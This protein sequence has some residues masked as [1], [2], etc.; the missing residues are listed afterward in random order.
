[1]RKTLTVLA[2]IL[3]TLGLAAVY[4]WV[5]EEG[6]VVFSDR[7]RDGAEEVKLPEVSTYT[8]APLPVPEEP[9]PAQGEAPGYP[10]LTI[11]EPAADATIWDAQGNV[12]VQLTLKPELDTTAGHKIRITIDGVKQAQESTNP[13]FVLTNVARGTHTL[14]VSVIDA[15]GKVLTSSDPVTFH[16]HRPIANPKPPLSPPSS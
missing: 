14:Q 16:L 5:D 6:N 9:A 12:P 4:K 15:D 13:R 10:Q 3:P 8:P 2:C 7:P 11:E 1:M